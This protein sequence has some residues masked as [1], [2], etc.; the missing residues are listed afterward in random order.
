[1][2]AALAPRTAQVIANALDG[3]IQEQTPNEFAMIPLEFKEVRRDSCGANTNC[4]ARLAW[5]V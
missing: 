3:R 1:V 5:V 4:F 2:R